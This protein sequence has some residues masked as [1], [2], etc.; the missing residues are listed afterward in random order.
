MKQNE[1]GGGGGEMNEV[2]ISCGGKG[3]HEFTCPVWAIKR[4][5]ALNL[6][7]S[8]LNPGQEL[9]EEEK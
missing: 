8:G 7:R 9:R 1:R 6:S 2:C 4:A 5:E 3:K